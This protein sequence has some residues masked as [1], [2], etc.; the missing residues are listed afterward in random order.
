MACCPK[1]GT[2]AA[3]GTKFC[4]ECGSPMHQPVDQC[5]PK[6]GTETHGA[7]FCPN[8]APRS[9]RPPRGLPELRRGNQ[10]RQVLPG[11]RHEN[12]LICLSYFPRIKPILRAW[13]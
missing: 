11:M 9:N 4:P 6:C 7:K 8:A 10:G 3:P 1:D 12:R 5:C 2:L 13:G